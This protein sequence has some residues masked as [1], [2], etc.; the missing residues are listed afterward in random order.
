LGR[1]D[2]EVAEPGS[3]FVS[4]VMND[5]IAG[6]TDTMTGGRASGFADSGPPARQGA[7]TARQRSP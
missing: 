3:A 5:I 6:A 1:D 2:R 4:D 7:G